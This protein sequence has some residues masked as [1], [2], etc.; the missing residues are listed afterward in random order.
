MCYQR[1]NSCNLISVQGTF[2][3]SYLLLSLPPEHGS[4]TLCQFNAHRPVLIIT[5]SQAQLQTLCMEAALHDFFKEVLHLA[6]RSNSIYVNISDR[7]SK[8]MLL[9]PFLL[10]RRELAATGEGLHSLGIASGHM[11]GAR[12][13]RSSY[14]R[15]RDCPKSSTLWSWPF[16]HCSIFYAHHVRE[17]STPSPSKI[18]RSQVDRWVSCDR[19]FSWGEVWKRDQLMFLRIERRV[20][21]RLDRGTLC[22]IKCL[23]HAPQR[24]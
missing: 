12:P 10:Y 23:L 8:P 24:N 21:H 4:I 20:Q 17:R 9:K 2:P 5:L 3:I 15:A 16:K 18:S 6:Q 13:S 22:H 19:T 7:N 1:P 14:T 11:N